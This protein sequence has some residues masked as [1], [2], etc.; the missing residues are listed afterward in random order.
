MVSSN[1]SASAEGEFGYIADKAVCAEVPDI[2]TT[3]SALEGL[4]ATD[5]NGRTGL[6]TSLLNDQKPYPLSKVIKNLRGRAV[7]VAPDAYLVLGS[8]GEYGLYYYPGNLDAH[9]LSGYGIL[10]IDGNARLGE[11]VDWRGLIFAKGDVHFEGFGSKEIF[12]AFV[13]EGGVVI[14]SSPAFYYDCREMNTLR[15]KFSRYQRRL[16]TCD[17][18]LNW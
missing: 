12:G 17:V 18:P 15:K 11:T 13:G 9:H 4:Q 7:T 16:W 6:R 1:A 10:M 5:F 8:S 2:V 3:S 14:D